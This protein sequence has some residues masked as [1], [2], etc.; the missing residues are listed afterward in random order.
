MKIYGI[1]LITCYCFFFLPCTD[2]TRVKM[3]EK[4]LNFVRSISYNKKYIMRKIFSAAQCLYISNV[5]KI[6][7]SSLKMTPLCS[8][9]YNHV[10]EL[11]CLTVGRKLCLF[12]KT[13]KI[14]TTWCTL[15]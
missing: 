10:N 7:S 3:I 15:I 14:T 8:I 12:R 1:F 11:L 5:L 4:C 6:S 9:S 13:M 2:V